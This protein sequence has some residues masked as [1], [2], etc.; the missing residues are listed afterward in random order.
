MED[1]FYWEFGCKGKSLNCL[2]DSGANVS[3]I[4]AKVVAKYGLEMKET[5]PVNLSGALTDK[6]HISK[7]AA[8]VPLSQGTWETTVVAYVTPLTGKDMIHHTKICGLH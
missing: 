7:Y 5:M 3:L 1:L 4:D 6:T 8:A 2:M